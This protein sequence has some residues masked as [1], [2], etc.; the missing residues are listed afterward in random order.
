MKQES[1]SQFAFKAVAYFSISNFNKTFMS[2]VIMYNIIKRTYMD[3]NVP[4]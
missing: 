3:K 4:S 1:I 2:K